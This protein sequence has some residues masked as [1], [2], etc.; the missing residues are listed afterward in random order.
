MTQAAI[1]ALVCFGVWPLS[2]LGICWA[3][4]M[5]FCISAELRQLQ[6]RFTKL[7]K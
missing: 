2:A 1:A 6:N 4:T 3:N 5:L 7:Q